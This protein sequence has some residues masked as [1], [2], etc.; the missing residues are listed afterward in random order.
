MSVDE[1]LPL[2]TV[3]SLKN[4][5]GK[6]LIVGVFPKA[7]VNNVT[8]DYCGLLLPYG[9][10]NADDIFLFNRDKIDKIYF[11]GYYDENTKEFYEDILW[12]RNLKE[13][14]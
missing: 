12:A 1:L 7:S 6:L 4:G 10:L 11:K 14:E 9:Y 3:V 8:Y 2:G 13:N 5:D